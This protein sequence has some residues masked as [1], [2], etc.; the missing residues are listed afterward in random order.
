MQKYF[1]LL[2]NIRI[3]IILFFWIRWIFIT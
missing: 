1:H 3:I 2:V